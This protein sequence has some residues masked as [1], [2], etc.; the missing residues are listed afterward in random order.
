MLVTT[1]IDRSE[2]RG[3]AAGRIGSLSLVISVAVKEAI[4]PAVRYSVILVVS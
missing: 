2:L 3:G 4:T 1:A